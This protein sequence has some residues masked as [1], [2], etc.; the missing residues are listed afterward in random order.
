MFILCHH[1][2]SCC[3]L[4][5]HDEI[6]HALRPPTHAAACSHIHLV[7]ITP[8]AIDSVRWAAFQ[9]QRHALPTPP[10]T[11]NAQHTKQYVDAVHQLGVDTGTPVIDLWSATV[12][13][14]D[15]LLFDG[16]HLSGD[17]NMVLFQLLMAHIAQHCPTLLPMVAPLDAPL[18]DR[19]DWEEPQKSF[20]L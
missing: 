5:C 4:R 20:E 14:T 18:F 19:I 9:Q 17:G 1:L 16:L 7:L 15:R 10:I 12:H 2:R 3:M 8:P 13:D 6:V 11:R